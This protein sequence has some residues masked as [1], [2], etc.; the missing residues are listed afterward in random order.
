[1]SIYNLLMTIFINMPQSCK[2]KE[3]VA[4]INRIQDELLNNHLEEQFQGFYLLESG[5]LT[6]ES[7]KE[8]HDC[9]H[10]DTEDGFKYSFFEFGLSKKGSHDYVNASTGCFCVKIDITDLRRQGESTA[11]VGKKKVEGL[12]TIKL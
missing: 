12:Q 2:N 8:V 10:N 1:M 4:I 5:N 7:I 9:F 11:V 6:S 3:V